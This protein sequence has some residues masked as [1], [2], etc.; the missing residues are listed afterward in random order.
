MKCLRLS[1]SLALLWAACA[2]AATPTPAD[3][4]QFQA[5]VEHLAS[6]QMAGRLPG[7]PGIRLARDY[8][9]EHFRSLGLKPAVTKGNESSFLQ[10]FQVAMAYVPPKREKGGALKAVGANRAFLGITPDHNSVG[11]VAVTDV[12]PGGP[13]DK[14]GMKPGDQITH[15]GESEIR[16]YYDLSAQL[17][18]AN[19]GD[20]V[21]I[22]VNRNDQ[23]V[24]LEV[25]PGER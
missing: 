13:A 6:E 8:I 23:T 11:S 12:V 18:D 22:T 5:R 21:K 2:A 16:N 17:R 15:W 14:A 7:T 4:D 9:L 10:P 3:V 19:P 24:E 25:T 1:L 20:T